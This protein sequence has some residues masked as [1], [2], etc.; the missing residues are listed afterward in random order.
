MTLRIPL[1]SPACVGVIGVALG[2]LASATYQTV[3]DIGDRRRFPPLGELVDIG[4]RRLHLWRAGAGGPA[5]V[6]APSLGE[7]G[8]G[9]AEIQR[10]LAQRTTVVL[11]DRAGVG[12]SDPG[13]WPTGKQ[14]VADLYALLAAASIPP[15]YIF[16]GHSAGGLLVRLYAALHPEQV[17]GLV[18]VDSS[19]PDQQR[20]LREQ[21]GGWRFS[22]PNWWLRTARVAFRPLGLARLRAKL[23]DR[24]AHGAPLHLP[25][26]LSPEMAAAATAMQF[27]TR[28]R[29][30]DV[31]EM[32][33][34][35]GFA[36]EVDR[37]VDGAPGS[38]GR[39][40]LVVITRGTA[41]PWPPEA[42][43]V[44]QELQAELALLSERGVHLHAQSGDH[45]IHRADPDLVANAIDD[46]VDQIRSG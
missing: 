18:L 13:P 20:R 11:Y 19:H 40:P 23:R 12:W 29:R 16:V 36:R 25:R 44:W 5:V 31:C 28:Q 17:V 6:V 41:T 14:M 9:W 30:A 43:A 8:Y 2:G 3:A 34:F 1:R 46:L 10:R 4:G 21:L 7:P 35:P 33:A 15:P 22:R 45:F 32:A 39:L 37:A 24:Y 27:G 26:G 42:E 38:L